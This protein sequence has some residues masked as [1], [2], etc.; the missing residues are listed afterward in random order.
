[1]SK[2]ITIGYSFNDIDID[3]PLN[4]TIESNGNIQTINCSVISKTNPQWLQI[5]KF[6]LISFKEKGSY[7]PMFNEK[8]NEKNQAT[9]LFIDKVYTVIMIAE[10]LKV[11]A[12]VENVA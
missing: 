9:S 12:D 8:N 1:M 11:K 3:I 6:D 5:R 7:I 4:Y 2:S 10:K